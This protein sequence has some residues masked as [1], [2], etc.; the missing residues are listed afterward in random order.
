MMDVDCGSARDRL[1]RTLGGKYHLEAILGAGG[2]AVIYRAQQRDGQMV[3][4]KVLHDHLSRS[5]EVCRRF[6][7]EGQLG[8]VLDHSG[9]V[10]VLDHGSTEEG[11]PYLVLELLEGESLEERRVRSGGR[12][13]LSETLELTEQLLAVLE[14]AHAKNIIHRDIKPSNLFLTNAG[15]LKVLDFGIARIADDTSSTSTK[16]GQMV[17]TPAFMPPE[18]AL[19]RPREI[20]ARTDIWSV[21][22]TM[23]TLLSG[24]HVHIAESSSEHLVKAATLHARSLAKVLPG[25]PSNVEALVARCLAFDKRERWSTAA[26]MRAELAF[27]RVDPGRGI[28]TNTSPPPDRYPSNPNVPTIIGSM[29]EHHAAATISS[30]ERTAERTSDA[31]MAVTSNPGASDG[32]SRRRWFVPFMLGSTGLLAATG[33]LLIFLSVRSTPASAAVAAPAKTAVRA[34]RGASVLVLEAPAAVPIRVPDAR[35]SAVDAATP[36][37]R[38]SGAVR[39]VAPSRAGGAALAGRAGGSAS[40]KD[41]YRPF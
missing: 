27:V 7:R 6:V 31:V 21:G 3:A 34:A 11:C 9:V 23:F 16:T 30:V 20:D 24:E 28:G 10:R 32:L 15:Q 12:L 37:P 17:G 26:S 14:V 40:R 18:Q 39:A 36:A 38:P 41:V 1:G 13:E 35:P 4:V 33:A 25:V 2:T 19:S 5:D 8:N 22:A 29:R